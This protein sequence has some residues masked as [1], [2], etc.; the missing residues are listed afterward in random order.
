L[1]SS[2][3]EAD[4]ANQTVEVVGDLLIEAIELR[5]LV[6]LKTGVRGDRSEQAGGQRRID[7][8]EKFQ[9]DEANR[10]AVRQ[11]LIPA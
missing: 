2:G 5:S 11:E 8:L 10:V 1:I 3:F 6:R 9:E 4:G 7:A